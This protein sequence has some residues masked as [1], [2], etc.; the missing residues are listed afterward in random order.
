[1]EKRENHRGVK[2][3]F[4]HIAS[5]AFINRN[6]NQRIAKEVQKFC[7]K[8]SISF[9][10]LDWQKVKTEENETFEVLLEA[11][12]LVVDFG[13][14]GDGALFLSG[15]IA[16][17]RN[18]DNLLLFEPENVKSQIQA[19]ELHHLMTP[20]ITLPAMGA[21][22]ETL[23]Y[24]KKKGRGAGMLVQFEDGHEEGFSDYLDRKYEEIVSTSSS[25]S[26][27]DLFWSTYE[28]AKQSLKLEKIREAEIVMMEEQILTLE[29][30]DIESI[31][32]IDM[33]LRLYR[34]IG[35][36]DEVVRL[37]QSIT[38][39]FEGCP[40]FKPMEAEALNQLG[41]L[42]NATEAL[43]IAKILVAAEPNS[44]K[45]KMIKGQVHITLLGHALDQL[46]EC[47]NVVPTDYTQYV[48]KAK[49]LATFTSHCLHAIHCMDEVYHLESAYDVESPPTLAAGHLACALFC[50]ALA[51]EEEAVLA[52]KPIPIPSGS[53]DLHRHGP[54]RH[55]GD[56]QC[57]AGRSGHSGG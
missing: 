19:S 34:Q 18:K 32:H 35:R 36:Y 23:R 39:H 3:V 20:G 51:L 57:G 47:S 50:R 43:K 53:T 33:M 25:S 2:R 24:T 37:S 16:Q 46:D 14:M 6:R 12:M 40:A 55:P 28:A 44:M 48:E 56:P 9:K 22:A 31:Q 7:K 5:V 30:L 26:A 1:M 11:D 10:P 42:K 38:E 15:L 27:S 45:A 29:E 54:T 17:R 52:C 8:H 13:Q 41:G 49:V 21:A 4:K